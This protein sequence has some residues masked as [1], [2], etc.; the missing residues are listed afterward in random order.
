[1]A[2]ST[3]DYAGN[4]TL[5]DA[6]ENTG[7][8]AST[9]I[10]L[11]ETALEVGID[12]ETGEHQGRTI[13]HTAAALPFIE[14]CRYSRSD[15]EAQLDFVLQKILSLDVNAADNEGITALHLVST[16]SAFRVSELLRAGAGIELADHS[17]CTPIHYAPR[18]RQSNVGLLA[19]HLKEKFMSLDAANESGR[20][21]LPFTMQ[22]GRA[23]RSP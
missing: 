16:R 21:P 9:T 17:G 10:F 5:Y 13:L 12:P 11:L 20:I 14:H 19:S 3:T 8:L 15:C 7:P 2:P 4:T 1:M 18:A 23:F 22:L 6:V